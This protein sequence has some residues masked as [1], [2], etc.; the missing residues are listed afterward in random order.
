MSY[1]IKV[2]NEEGKLTLH[3]DYGKVVYLGVANQ[4]NSAPAK[5]YYNREADIRNDSSFNLAYTLAYEYT[6]TSKFILPFIEF[7]EFYLFSIIDCVK[8]SNNTWI[9]HCLSEKNTNLPVLRIFGEMSTELTSMYGIAVRD[10]LGKLIFSSDRKYLSIYDSKLIQYPNGVRTGAAD[11]HTPNIAP[12][13]YQPSPGKT[14]DMNKWYFTISSAYCGTA[15]KN[16]YSYSSG[17]WCVKYIGCA[18]SY[19]TAVL[20]Q[21]WANHRGAFKISGGAIT[22]TYAQ[23][24]G[25]K[26]WRI[27]SGSCGLS[28]ILGG[29]IAG[30]AIYFTA[31]AALAIVGAYAAY[32]YLNNIEVPTV[33]YVDHDFVADTNNSQLMLVVDK[34]NYI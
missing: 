5:L 28:G 19:E 2:Y 15:Y 24:Y 21:S 33:S 34:N 6:S 13:V 25:G 23:Q 1:G 12:N 10:N 4:L 11:N 32:S 8:T 3:S 31:G 27:Q 16:S 9:I 14:Y 18:G 22:T 26:L 7:S 17:C 20:Q 29:L 30:V